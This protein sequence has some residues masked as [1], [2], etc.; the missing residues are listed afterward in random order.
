MNRLEIVWPAPLKVPVKAAMP[1]PPTGTKPV[2]GFQMS[3]LVDVAERSML[4][5]SV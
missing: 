4:P 3:A 5:A 1:L 2:A